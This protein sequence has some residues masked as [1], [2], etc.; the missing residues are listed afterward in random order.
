VA[1][2]NKNGPTL[3]ALTRQNLAVFDREEEG[4]GAAEGLLRGGY[5]FY[6]KAPH[7]LELVLIA[8]GSEVEIAYN[9]A[10]TLAAE[11]VG[12][13]VVSLAS[14]ELFAKQGGVYINEILPVGV[15]KL[16]IEAASPFGW[17]RWIGNDPHLGA[18][19]G[20]NHFGASAPYQRIYE[21]FGLTPAHAVAKAKQL[22]GR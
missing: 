15:K 9:A 21:E 5:V 1:L 6:E 20:I 22:L 7:G 11:G 18:M 2:E 12:V 10:K 16:A 3:M 17:E 4:V 8:S 14:W 13:R 19:I